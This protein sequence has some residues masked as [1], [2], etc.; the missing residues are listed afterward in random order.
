MLSSLANAGVL[1][2]AEE[3]GLF[4]KLE[5]AGAFS[6][7]EKLLPIADD[8]K[9]LSLAETLL[10]IPSAVLAL[11]AVGL[12][13]GGEHRAPARTRA[14]APAAMEMAAITSRVW[15]RAACACVLSGMSAWACARSA[16]EGGFFFALPPLPLGQCSPHA[17]VVACAAQ[18]S[19]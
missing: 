12:V 19:L 5:R 6:S 18:R 17:F 7:A 10:D 16:R 8:L 2:S 9:L 3:A 11:A 14:L 1:S 15:W 13:G 4:T